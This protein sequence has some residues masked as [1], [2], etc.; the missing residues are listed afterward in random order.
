MNT[1]RVVAVIVGKGAAVTRAWYALA[2]KS[3]TLAQ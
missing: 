3:S 1:V 2:A